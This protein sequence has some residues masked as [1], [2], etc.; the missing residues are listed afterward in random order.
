SSPRRCVRSQTFDRARNLSFSVGDALDK[1]TNVGKSGNQ[2]DDSS[3]LAPR[4]PQG[5][6]R[7]SG[8]ASMTDI[9]TMWRRASVPAVLELLRVRN[10]E[11][12]ALKIARLELQKARRA[13]SRKRFDFWSAV[14][15]QLEVG[16]S[17]KEI[18]EPRAGD[19]RVSPG[20]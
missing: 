12:K 13:R 4:A 11:A 3:R 17:G 7:R 6:P 20:R 16:L 1:L 5:T 14:S 15:I 18:P 10:G 9:E 8:G 2:A 19:E